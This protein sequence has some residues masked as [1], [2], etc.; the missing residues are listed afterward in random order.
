V[1]GLG[2]SGRIFTTQTGIYFAGKYS[3][4]CAKTLIDVVGVAFFMIVVTHPSFEYR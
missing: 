3:K 1:A 4:H 2:L